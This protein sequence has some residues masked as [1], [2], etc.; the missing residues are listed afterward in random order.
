[1]LINIYHCIVDIKVQ[2]KYQQTPERVLFTYADVM[3]S[4]VLEVGLKISGE[5]IQVHRRRRGGKGI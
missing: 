3:L 1:M 2:E 4:I 5:G